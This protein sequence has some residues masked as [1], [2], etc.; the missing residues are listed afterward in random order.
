M[1]LVEI[2]VTATGGVA[3]GLCGHRLSLRREWARQRGVLR[4]EAAQQLLVPLRALRDLFRQ[5]EHEAPTPET[6]GA[7]IVALAGAHDDVSHRLPQGWSHLL[8]SVRAA[9]GE[10]IGAPSL[11]DLDRRLTSAPVA[12][13]DERWRQHGLEYIDYVIFRLQVW[14]DEPLAREPVHSRLLAFD[15]WLALTGRHGHRPSP[16]VAAR[17]GWKRG[18]AREA[19]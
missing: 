2:V 6:W 3:A 11:A 4:N 9:A 8:R 5:S 12:Q 18:I 13:H 14:A 16:L 17:R 19:M 7:A 10:F 1:N 15:D